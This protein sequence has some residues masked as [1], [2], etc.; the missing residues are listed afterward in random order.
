MSDVSAPP[1]TARDD[2]AIDIGPL[3]QLVGYALRRA[4]LAVFQDFYATFAEF[5]IRPTQFSVLTVLR[6]NPGR[7]QSQIADALGIKRA[8]FVALFDGL[9]TRGLAERRPAPDDRRAH[10][11]YLTEAGA[12]LLDELAAPLARHEGRFI[13]R[14]GAADM[15]RLLTLLH[16][17]TGD[18]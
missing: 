7:R 1:C 11:L 2:D 17:I 13:A 6:H 4:Q 3:P 16:R 14:L 10:A 15:Q 8:N 18:G 5:D 9:R 12:A